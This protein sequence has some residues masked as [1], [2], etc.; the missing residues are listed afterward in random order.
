MYVTKFQKRGLPHVHMLLVLESND[1]LRDPKDYDSMVRAEI[2]K[3]ECEPKLQ[4][5]LFKFK[6]LIILLPSF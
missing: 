1:K 3:L 4:Q 5:I 6:P 2:P